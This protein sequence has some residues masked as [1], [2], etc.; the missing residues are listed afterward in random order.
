MEKPPQR[1]W[2]SKEKFEQTSS[3]GKMGRFETGSLALHLNKF[4][5]SNTMKSLDVILGRIKRSTVFSL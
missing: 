3:L 4:F 2:F 1:G 5:P